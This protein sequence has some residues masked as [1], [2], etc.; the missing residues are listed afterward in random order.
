[1]YYFSVKKL[2]DKYMNTQYTVDYFIKKFEA[3]PDRLY[4]YGVFFD[5]SGARCANGWCG[6]RSIHDTIPEEAQG[7][8]KVFSI[9]SCEKN[10]DSD[11]YPG[12]SDIAANINNG[13][14]DRY[15]QPSEKSRILAA[16]Y[17]IKAM[18]QPKHEDIT[19]EL[20]VLPAD[21]TSDIILGKV[22]QPS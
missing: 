12:Y 9:L 22:I 2:K 1:M 13:F 17:D 6:V 8:Q 20:A 14:D 15:K 10:H 5:D 7:L 11:G 21:E 3:I 19:K 18:Q 16:L 4:A